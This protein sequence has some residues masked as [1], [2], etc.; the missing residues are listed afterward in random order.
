MATLMQVET[1]GAL[2]CMETASQ[3]RRRDLTQVFSSAYVGIKTEV[4]DKDLFETNAIGLNR[5]PYTLATDVSCVVSCCTNIGSDTVMVPL[6]NQPFYRLPD[7]TTIN[8]SGTYYQQLKTRNGCD[9]TAFI[10]VALQ[11]S[12]VISLGEDRCLEG[13]DSVIL[14]ATGGYEVYNWMNSFRKDSIYAVKAPGTYWVSVSNNCGYKTDSVVVYQGCDFDD[15]MPDAFTP[16]N[17]GKNDVFRY[18]VQSPN[19]FVRLSVFNRWGQ[20]VF[21]TR[22][23]ASGWSGN[24]GGVLQETGTYVY[25]LETRTPNGKTRHQKGTVTLIR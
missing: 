25:I 24:V 16:N 5:K 9:S 3:I 7:G 4:A 20:K 10:A 18:P 22:N 15:Y 14:K 21:E 11:Q 2:A 1:N 12:P 6:C 17:D 23:R 13:N 19:R 8:E